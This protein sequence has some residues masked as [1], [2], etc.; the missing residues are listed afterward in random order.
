MIEKFELS[1]RRACRLVGLSRD[2]HR[3]PPIIHRADQGLRLDQSAARVVGEAVEVISWVL[4]DDSS[5]PL[6][7]YNRTKFIKERR[8][9]M[10]TW[11]DYLDKIKTGADVISLR[12]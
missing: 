7:A 3:H 2:S 6:A 12:A 5:G 10:Q 4:P 8:R 11:A 1:E 9:M